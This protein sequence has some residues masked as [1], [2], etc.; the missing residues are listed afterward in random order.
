[1]AD[2]WAWD[3]GAWHQAATSGPSPRYAASL[4]YDAARSVYVLYGG[5]TAKGS[6]NETWTW[7]GTKWKALSPAHNPGPRRSAAMA[8]DTKSQVVLLYGGLVQN[9]AEGAPHA[10]TWSWDGVDW[11]MLEAASVQPGIRIGS[12]MVTA[13]GRVLLFGGSVSSNSDFFA[14]ASTWDGRTWSRIDHG[15]TP[16]GRG[17]AAV[18]WDEAHSSLFVFGGGGLN[19]QAGGGAAGKP[20][21]DAWSLRGASWTSLAGAGPQPTAQTNGMWDKKAGRAIVIFGM[22]GITCPNPTNEVWTWD[23]TSWTHLAKAAVPAR[24]GAAL[25]QAPD[26]AGIVFGGSDEPGC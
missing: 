22:S 23:G 26:G 9:T 6:S 25:A 3:G 5:Q 1:M 8:Y 11:K 7:D 14:D 17:D 2:T 13:G 15:P 21:A 24:W 4:A 16:P 20:L 19:A 18:V 10:D 12:R